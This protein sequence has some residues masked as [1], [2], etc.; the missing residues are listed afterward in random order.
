MLKFNVLQKRIAW[1]I[2]VLTTLLY[3]LTLEPSVSFWDCGEFI[4]AAYKLQVG[5]PPG[6]PF[7]L[8]LARFFSLF[9]FGHVEIVAYLINLV[10]VFASSFT[11]FFLFWTVILLAKKIIP[12]FISEDIRKQQLLILVVAAI[13]SLSYAFTDSFWFSAVEGEVYALSSLFTAVVFW[14]ILKWEE[15]AHSQQS[16]KWLVLIAL[17]VGISIGV[18]LLN[19]LTIP[20]MVLVYYFK[21]FSVSRNGIIVAL[22]S[23]V[24]LVAILMWGVIPG[25]PK[26]GAAFDYLFVNSFGASRNVGFL[27]YLFFLFALL[28]FALF[29]SRKKSFRKLHTIVL[30]SLVF[31]IG[32][33]SYSVI[34]IRSLA[35]TPMD[36]NNPEN[37]Y[38]L[39]SYLNRDQYGASPLLFGQ[40]YNAPIV[41]YTFDK[42]VVDYVD[43]KYQT[44]THIPEAVYHKDFI[45]FFPR[46]WS[47]NPQHI[48]A[49][50]QWANIKDGE[51]TIP[52]Y[53][54]GQTL[55]RPS[56]W[57]NV[58]FFMKYQVGHMYF[59]Y[60]M[61]NFSGRQNDIQG[62]GEPN[63][64]NWITGIPFLDNLRLGAQ[65]AMPEY[66]KNN[67]AHNV[68]FAFPFILGF[69]GIFYLWRRNKRIAVVLLSLFFFTGIAIVLYLNQYPF[70][71]RERDYA[72]AG[73]FYA[74][75]I[76]IGFGV[77]GLYEYFKKLLPKKAI[78]I[79][80]SLACLSPVVLAVENWDDHDR[81]ERYIARDFS[82]NYLSTCDENAILFTLGDNDTFPLWYLQEV[83]GYRTDVKIVNLSLFNMDWYISQLKKKTYASAGIPS[84]LPEYKY[85]RGTNDQ[86]YA[87]LNAPNQAYPAKGLIDLVISDNIQYKAMQGEGQYID[88]L[89]SPQ[90]I[91]EVNKDNVIASK[92]VPEQ[93]QN[94]IQSTVTFPIVSVDEQGYV[95]DTVLSKSKLLLLDVLASNNWERPVYF[96]TTVN[97]DYY[98]NLNN[99]LFLE[100]LAY[101]FLPVQA[102]NNSGGMGAINTAVM[103]KKLMQEF[104][105]GNSSEAGVY[106]DE[107]SMNMIRNYRQFFT[108]L[109][110]ALIEENQMEKAQNVLD[111]CVE[112]FPESQVPYAY[113][114]IYLANEYYAVGQIEKAHAIH[115]KV[116]GNL[117]ENFLYYMGVHESDYEFVINDV[118]QD[119]S[120]AISL[121]EVSQGVEQTTDAFILAE[122]CTSLMEHMFTF[123]KQISISQAETFEQNN[124][125]IFQLSANNQY[126]AFWYNNMKVYLQSL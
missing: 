99:N 38:T 83:E 53:I 35:N 66:L 51:N 59:R 82:K 27:I 50:E 4:S 98:F 126:V 117:K 90:A 75:S 7:Y 119:L 112:L 108:G 74:F 104:T 79:A 52:I 103:Y 55:H 122:S 47:D 85:R 63:K 25:I 33:S 15:Q 105:W 61:W 20:A 92:L 19:I 17:I 76:F 9:A 8:L 31:L 110:H 81:S 37:P 102:T 3:I 13:S 96:S 94:Q 54:N 14:A 107:N 11:I 58:K 89:H 69:I 73:S 57:Q 41:D 80:I 22:I 48:A 88:I 65:D 100:G 45:T 113:N 86:I 5:H 40:T 124:E 67:K 106:L 116:I 109:A 78:T 32:Y 29:Y 23:S 68:Y 115:E 91:L 120:M 26:I 93:L 2:W 36:E 28:V 30:M 34:V 71:P 64:G 121:F 44:L 18:H 62:H 24:L 16:D 46:M 84:T 39:L 114:A 95:T 123:T 125:W 6:A 1:L 97:K 43:G 72:F 12:S 111:R 60:F 77:L 10:S 49:Y 70:Q 56:F 42:E 101:K 21:R 118:L 87:I